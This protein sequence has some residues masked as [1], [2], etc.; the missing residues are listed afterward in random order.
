MFKKL[1]GKKIKDVLFSHQEIIFFYMENDDEKSICYI[2]EEPFAILQ[3][4]NIMKIKNQIVKRFYESDNFFNFDVNDETLI[5]LKE[6]IVK[7]TDIIKSS[8]LHEMKIKAK[9]AGGEN[10]E[11]N[12]VLANGRWVYSEFSNH[13][14]DWYRNFLISLD[15]P[16]HPS[17]RLDA[18]F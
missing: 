16:N 11:I 15:I 12:Y 8:N 14:S 5:F 6:G 17:I 2:V 9:L 10:I 4:V 7:I 3:P 1:V 18:L 13:H